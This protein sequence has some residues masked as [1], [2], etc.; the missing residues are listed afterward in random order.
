MRPVLPISRQI[1][2]NVTPSVCSVPPI[3]VSHALCVD[4]FCHHAAWMID[5]AIHLQMDPV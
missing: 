5:P 1:L 2:A 3:F 4:N